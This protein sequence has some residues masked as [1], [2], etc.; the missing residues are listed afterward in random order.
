MAARHFDI[1]RPAYRDIQAWESARTTSLP[2]IP[3]LS[4]TQILRLRDEA[5]TALPKFRERM[6]RLMGSEQAAPN[7]QTLVSE[8]RDEAA[9]VENELRA[10][11]KPGKDR[12]RTAQGLVGL[13]ISVYGYAAEALSPGMAL[14]GLMALWQQ[15]HKS[16]AEVEQQHAQIISKPGYVLVKAKELLRHSDKSADH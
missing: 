14:G 7:P 6:T 10:L 3:D 4:M 2:W 16:H 5:D 8:L 9:E 12:T 13:A 15:I 1:G 11:N